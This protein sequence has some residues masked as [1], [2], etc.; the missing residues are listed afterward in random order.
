M[1]DVAYTHAESETVRETSARQG[2]VI[3]PFYLVCDVSGSMSG[4][5]DDLTKAVTELVQDIQN[6]PVVDDLV[7]L[8]VITFNHSATTVVPL[9]SPSDITPPRFS[10]GGGTGYSAAFTEYHR[11]FEQDRARLKS[12]GMRV[13]R[14]CVFF[15]TDGEPND[16]HDYLRT[17]R[18]LLAWDPE[19]KQGNKAFPYFVPFGF[20]DATED[21]VK[22]LA[23]PTFGP[24]RGRWFLSR[25]NKVSEV[26]KTIRDVLGNTVISSGKSAGAGKPTIVPPTAQAGPDLQFGEA[27]DEV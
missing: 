9:S 2:Q 4:D 25:S 16:H 14:P 5:V 17:F 24:A 3:M 12:Q 8:S 15:L 21:V 23:Y 20:R 22:S 11:A 7:M 1:S 27:G 18:S 13:Y 6:D 26:L 10:A 19:T